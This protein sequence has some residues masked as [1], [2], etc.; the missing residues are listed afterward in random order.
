MGFCLDGYIAI[1]GSESTVLDVESGKIVWFGGALHNS[2]G[3]AGALGGVPAIDP[4]CQHPC[5]SDKTA[6]AQDQD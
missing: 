5:L 1:G 6:V 2:N 4:L 3:P